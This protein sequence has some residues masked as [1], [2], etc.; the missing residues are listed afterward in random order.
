MTA[1]V[2][3]WRLL[4]RDGAERA[5]IRQIIAE[6]VIDYSYA[7]WDEWLTLD[8]VADACIEFAS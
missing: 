5:E 7:S 8:A 4:A 2:D 6:G 3:P 1:T